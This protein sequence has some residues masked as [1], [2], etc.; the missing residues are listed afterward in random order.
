MQVF[1]KS[2][3]NLFIGAIKTLQFEMLQR[4]VKMRLLAFFNGH[5][6]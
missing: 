5:W 3:Q 1:M 4:D 6:M 2:E